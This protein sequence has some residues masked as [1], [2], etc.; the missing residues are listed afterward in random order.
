MYLYNRNLL[1][2]FLE[3][4]LLCTGDKTKVSVGIMKTVPLYSTNKLPY[5]KRDLENWE[6]KS[7]M[8]DDLG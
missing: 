7:R 2:K 5:I 6:T 8:G 4:R 1:D 3:G